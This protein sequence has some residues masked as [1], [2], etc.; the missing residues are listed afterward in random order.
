M[1]VSITMSII[2]RILMID[3]V[4]FLMQMAK[5]YV[6]TVMIFGV[7]KNIVESDTNPF[8]YCGEYYDRKLVQSTFVPAAMTRQL[9]DLSQ[10]IALQARLKIHYH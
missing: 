2:S 6:H 3:V 8:R 10:E 9:D 4:T 5:L 7:E 1:V